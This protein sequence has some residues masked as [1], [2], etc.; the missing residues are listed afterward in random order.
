M[1]LLNLDWMLPENQWVSWGCRKKLKKVFCE[2]GV[3]R[4]VAKFTGNTCVRV[5]LLIKLQA[6][7]CNFIV[8]ETLVQVFSYEFY[9]FSK[10]T[11]SYRKTPVAASKEMNSKTYQFS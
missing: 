3:L 10:N 1:Y 9:E 2:K 7:T 6:K 11:F 5:S 4:S 8:K